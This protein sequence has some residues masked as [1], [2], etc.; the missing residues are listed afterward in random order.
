MKPLAAP[1]A[2]PEYFTP[3]V[4]TRSRRHRLAEAT[5][6]QGMGHCYKEGT[7]RRLTCTVQ[8]HPVLSGEHLQGSGDKISTNERST[9]FRLMFLVVD[10]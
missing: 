1:G 4:T 7:P 6:T 5:F 10:Y 3:A 9:C 2:P 8:A